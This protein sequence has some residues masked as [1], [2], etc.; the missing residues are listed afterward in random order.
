MDDLDLEII[1]VTSNWPK[2]VG[3]IPGR[4]KIF[5]FSASSDTFI[6]KTLPKALVLLYL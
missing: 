6:Y 1:K 3:R 4:A 2:V 5:F